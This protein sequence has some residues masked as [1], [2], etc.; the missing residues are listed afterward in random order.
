MKSN[1]I[2]INPKILAGKPCIAGTRIPVACILELLENG[3]SFDKV[4]QDYYPQLVK[5]DI[6]ACLEYAKTLIELKFVST[7]CQ[8]PIE[9]PASIARQKVNVLM[10][11]RVS[12]LL[13]SDEPQLV[14]VGQGR[15][16]WRVPVDLTYPEYGR[17]GRIAEIDVDVRYGMLDYT[18]AMLAE[19]TNKTKQLAR[20]LRQQRVHASQ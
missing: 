6:Q 4:I 10:L 7:E 9:I 1:R 20:Q 8:P 15:W 13:L 17:V 3:L 19:M 5:E 12:N 14:E 2:V 11:E 18:D 16:V